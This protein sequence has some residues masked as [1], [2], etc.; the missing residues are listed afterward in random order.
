MAEHDDA[1]AELRAWLSES[2][3]PELSLLEWR[4]RL[5]DARWACP[6]WPERWFG[7]GW[8]ASMAGLVADELERVGAP[9]LPDGVGMMLAAPTILEHGS[10]EL[11]DRLLPL[12][13]TGGASWCQ[14]FSEPGAGSDLAGLTTHATLDG[15]TWIVT[16]Q[17][18]WNTSAHHADY[19]L[20]LAR[21]DWDAPKHRGI[22][23]FALPMRQPGVEVRPLRQMN[24]HASFNEV[25]LDEAQVP[26]GNAIGAPGDGWAVAL[27]TLA[28][29]RRLAAHRA[30]PP[31]VDQPGRAMREARA[32]HAIA[33]APYTWYPQRGGR[34]DLLAEHAATAR[35][36]HD[37]IVR[38]AI[39]RTLSMDAVAKWTAARALAARAL[40]RPPGAEGSIGKL[41]SSAIARA[42][43][44]THALIAGPDAMTTGDGSPF[45][46]VIAEILVSVPAVSLAGGTDEIQHNILAERVLGLP[47]EPDP[48]RGEP[49]RAVLRNRS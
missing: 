19:G 21:T 12:T 13:V 47:K 34:S 46:G 29:E 44:Q 37:P 27:T 15:D 6:T 39:A 32:E 20:L 28:H 40:G 4:R 38:Q 10:D 49:F 41:A 45:G 9:G 25:F 22:T 18:V 11:R 3:D 31:H 8:P 7:R 42:A 1:R 30:R 17:K 2:W 23:G 26:A 35:R 43:A 48:T 24:G 16:G 14:L 5:T 33:S 36:S